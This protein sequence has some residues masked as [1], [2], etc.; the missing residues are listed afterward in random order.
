MLG[1]NNLSGMILLELDK[2]VAEGSTVTIMAPQQPA[3]REAF[4]EKSMKRWNRRLQNLKEITHVQADLGSHF[5]LESLPV[6]QASRIFILSS[7]EHEETMTS[8]SMTL[9]DAC[10]FAMVLQLEHIL[11]SR[12][13]DSVERMPI[14]A[15]IRD[16]L[17]TQQIAATR[18]ADFINLSGVPAQVL[19]MIA[20]QPRIAEVLELI[21]SDH[22]H[23]S[24]AVQSMEM[25]LEP[26]TPVPE[27]VSFFEARHIAHKC[28][29]IA[30]GWSLPVD[31]KKQK[32][33]GHIKTGTEWQIN[34][35]DKTRQRE[36]SRSDDKLVVLKLDPPSN[37]V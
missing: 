14:V 9:A 21:I 35:P 16:T 11:K 29:D 1:W 13:E 10:T 17:T 31:E 26:G 23:V 19:A 5:Q 12:L 27:K 3:S 28:G 7:Q 30:I 4:L 24:F 32:S 34:P 15:E 22:A 6:E 37:R 33:K 25:Y 20:H 8:T 2:E 36:W 18:I